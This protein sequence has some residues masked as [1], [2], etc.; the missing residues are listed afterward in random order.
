MVE[1]AAEQTGQIGASNNT[2]SFDQTAHKKK[3]KGK[4]PM[5]LMN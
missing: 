1:Y 4:K 2:L 3:E 5:S